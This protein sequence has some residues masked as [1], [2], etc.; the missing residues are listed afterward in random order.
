MPP[1]D[2]ETTDKKPP[3]DAGKWFDGLAAGLFGLVFCIHW[4]NVWTFAVDMPFWDEWDM[5]QPKSTWAWIWDPQGEHRMV[6]TKLMISLLMKLNGWDVAFHQTLNFAIYGITLGALAWMLRRCGVNVRAGFLWLFLTFTLSPR[7]SEIHHWA[8]TG[9]YHYALLFLFL[10]VGLLFPA[11][12]EGQG[13]GEIGLGTVCAWLALYSFGIALPGVALII[14]GYLWFKWSRSQRNPDS[15][16]REWIQA[17]LVSGLLAIGL[18]CYRI[19]FQGNEVQRGLTWPT[20]G[21]FWEHF[22]N[23]C[24]TGFGFNV[25]LPGAYIFLMGMGLVL[26]VSWSHSIA[27]S[28]HQ[29][30]FPAGLAVATAAILAALAAT[31]LGRA[32]EGVNQASAGRY[33]EVTMMLIPLLAATLWVALGGK[34][35]LRTWVVTGYA[36][37]CVVG[38][39][40]S[41][42]QM[43]DY[44]DT[45]QI[46]GII[47]GRNLTACYARR[48][49]C[50]VVNLRGLP[51]DPE[52]LDEALRQRRSFM[53]KILHNEWYRN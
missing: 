27:R 1:V 47:E 43:R 2:S 42:P 14:P 26:V 45:Y 37:I 40:R 44:A 35:R 49:P 15:T 8:L 31:S 25:G 10:A 52:L 30:S 41:W 9:H 50:K 23:L 20:K 53:T 19:G 46:R 5:I 39:A 36:L 13:Y 28:R 24:A 18:V 7:A 11:R 38:F 16:R 34:S 4:F 33:T 17:G 6:T 51:V 21:V 3:L 12:T 32:N 48:V 29:G 22:A